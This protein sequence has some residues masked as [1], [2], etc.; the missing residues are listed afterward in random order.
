MPRLPDEELLWPGKSDALLDKLE[1][2]YASEGRPVEISL[3]DAVD[4]TPTGERLSH[5]V[6]PYPA[7][8]VRH[9]PVLFAYSTRYSTPG[10]VIMDPF[11]GSGTVLLESLAAG[12]RGIGA[13][14]NPLARLITLVKTTPVAESV[15]TDAVEQV[16]AAA[17]RVRSTDIPDVQNLEYW[18]GDQ[19]IRRLG[20]LKSAIGRSA[21]SSESQAFLDLCFSVV[22]R[23]CSLAD[24][25]ISVPV[26]LKDDQY[27]EGHWLREKTNRMIVDLPNRDPIREFASVG[28]ANAQ[29]IG[30]LFDRGLARPAQVDSEDARILVSPSGRRQRSGTVDLVIT[31]PPYVGAQKYIRASSLSLGWLGFTD[32]VGLREYDSQSI[33]REKFVEGDVQPLETGIAAADGVLDQVWDQN[34][35]R[36]TIAATYLIEMRD[37]LRESVRVLRPGGALVLVSGQNTVAGYPFDT[38]TYLHALAMELGLDAELE[39]VDTIRSRGLMTRRNK[40]TPVI[41]R[42]TVAVFRLPR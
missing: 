25:R 41:A 38:T 17:K 26:R 3:R 23:R 18:F 32:D 11:C 31:S 10:R 19:V 16:V 42:E 22:V 34:P 4:W 36:A 29:R 8:L 39:L 5:G 15:L 27:P 14:S 24:P 35:L 21:L 2:Q 20:R 13:D 6:H 40:S 9:V 37:A 1:G 30:R 28:S 7:R 33:G 12:R